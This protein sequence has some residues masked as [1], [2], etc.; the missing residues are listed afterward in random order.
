MA[1]VVAFQAVTVFVFV[2]AGVIA[3]IRFRRM[4]AA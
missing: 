4:P 3:V 1:A 2:A